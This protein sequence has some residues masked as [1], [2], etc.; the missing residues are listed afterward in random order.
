MQEQKANFD[1]LFFLKTRN[2]LELMQPVW[3]E[4][5]SEAASAAG[6]P[7]YAL[8]HRGYKLASSN[9]S[10]S[11]WHRRVLLLLLF[12]LAIRGLLSVYHLLPFGKIGED[13]LFRR[14]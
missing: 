2:K 8:L 5:K 3:S 4:A 11:P 7:D 13:L 12:L 10:Q 9:P 6:T 1:E 14:V